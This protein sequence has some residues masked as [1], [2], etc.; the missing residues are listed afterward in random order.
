[1]TTH[2]K[3]FFVY[4]AL[5]SFIFITSFNDAEAREQDYYFGLSGGQ[6]RVKNTATQEYQDA[7]SF[8]V[9]VGMRIYSSES[10]WAGTELK[11][12]QTTAKEKVNNSGSSTVSTYEVETTGLYLTGRT[13]SKAYVKGKIGAANQVIQLNDIVIQDSTKGSAGIG[14]GLRQGA[15]VLEIEYTLYG[16]DVTILSIGYVF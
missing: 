16:D 6:T 12:T 4:S 5:L 14:V 11:Y 9:K 2:I 3:E 7:T 1:M 8:G 10:L 15:A 13:R